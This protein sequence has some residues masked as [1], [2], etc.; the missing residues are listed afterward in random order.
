MISS[1]PIGECRSCGSAQLD[2]VI[3]L[4]NQPLANNL[5]R[6]ADLEREEPRFPLGIQ[7]CR[8]C[9]LVQLT[10]LVP[11]VNLFTD[12]L[13]FSSFSDAMLRHARSASHQHI[14]S[15][16]LGADS[17]VVEIASN[18]GYLLRN[19]VE[20]GIPCLGVE[21]AANVAAVA[22][23]CGVPTE[24]AFFG[25]AFAEDL[26][27]RR[28]KADLILG[29]NVFA[30]APEINDFVAGLAKLL[31]ADGLAVLEF[32]W[33]CELI[34]RIE[35][36]TIYHEHVFYFSLHSLIPLFRRH[37]LE[38]E[39]AERLDI[40]GGS[41]RIYARH[42]HRASPDG[43]VEA[44]IALEDK[45]GVRSHRYYETFAARV[46]SAMEALGKFITEKSREGAKLAVYGA[47]AKGSTLLNFL[48]PARDTLSFVADRNTHKQGL[49]SPG[50]HL[51]IVDPEMLLEEQPDYALLLSW[52]FA[53]EI[54]QQ[55]KEYRARGGKFI[56][57]IPE[58]RVV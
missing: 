7:A 39:A 53:D 58:L 38:I 31:S 47:S 18:D 51:P 29:N 28:G 49:Y 48:N 5:L 9:W 19:F 10:H 32:P 40:H 1:Q 35:F 27:G 14:S 34:D 24:V 26:M 43:T 21:P 44:L 46:V 8:N 17:F 25:E 57:P 55:Q 30:H 54:L 2:L 6:R 15:E 13:Y 20:A 16:G 36:D 37:G 41:L 11:P 33:L 45:K 56:I 12:Y 52:N 3:D 42:V 23:E 4:G 22:R 50:L